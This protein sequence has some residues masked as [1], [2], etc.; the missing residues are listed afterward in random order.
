MLDKFPGILRADKFHVCLLIPPGIYC[1]SSNV[2]GEGHRDAKKGSK[3]MNSEMGKISKTL[4]IVTIILYVL[5]VLFSL[6]GRFIPFLWHIIPY[7]V[8][9]ILH[10]LQLLTAVGAVLLGIV[11][12]TNKEKDQSSATMGSALGGLGIVL[13][14]LWHFWHIGLGTLVYL[15]F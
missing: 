12:I 15:I 11:A 7:I 5:P 4:G 3:L 9:T 10:W 6:L 1:P 8:W 14:I 13:W 2:K